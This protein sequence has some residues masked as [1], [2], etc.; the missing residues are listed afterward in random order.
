MIRTLI[1][2]VSVVCIHADSATRRG[3]I[4]DG[5][6][7]AR[8]EYPFTGL[9]G[10]YNPYTYQFFPVCGCTILGPRYVVTAAHCVD[11]EVSG[12]RL[13]VMT[14]VYSIDEFASD[15]YR[16]ANPAR[17]SLVKRADIHAEYDLSRRF[18]FTFEGTTRTL[19]EF[20]HDIALLELIDPTDWMPIQRFGNAWVVGGQNNV[21][22]MATAVGWGFVGNGISQMSDRPNHIE[23]PLVSQSRC[24]E[25]YWNVYANVYVGDDTHLCA[26]GLPN[27]GIC[28]GD[29]GSSLLK[30]AADGSWQLIGMPSFSLSPSP[31]CGAIYGEPT[32][33][34]RISSLSNWIC[35]RA[36]DVDACKHL[37]YNVEPAHNGSSF[38]VNLTGLNR[39]QTFLTAEHKYVLTALPSKHVVFHK[40]PLYYP[41]GDWKS[42]IGN[43]IVELVLEGDGS[44]FEIIYGPTATQID[45]RLDD[46]AIEINT[47]VYY[48]DPV[49]SSLKSILSCPQSTTPMSMAQIQSLM[50]DLKNSSRVPVPWLLDV[51]NNLVNLPSSL[52]F[53]L[54]AD[55]FGD[56]V[57]PGSLHQPIRRLSEEPP[58]IESINRSHP[59]F[60]NATQNTPTTTDP[61]QIPAQ[62]QQGNLRNESVLPISSIDRTMNV[63]GQQTAVGNSSNPSAQWLNGATPE[64]VQP[65]STTPSVPF[66]GSVNRNISQLPSFNGAPN[67]PTN[68]GPQVQ[69]R[70]TS[71]MTDWYNMIENS[72][73]NSIAQ[74]NLGTGPSRWATIQFKPSNEL[75]STVAIAIYVNDQRE[76]SAPIIMGGRL[77]VN[78]Y[79]VQQFC[80]IQSVT[81]D[82]IRDMMQ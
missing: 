52:K 37:S 47:D 24:T 34:T 55:E 56:G 66:I 32:V 51:Q 12:W 41:H 25:I 60:P 72:L 21:L 42:L 68:S 65:S 67:N 17:A 10:Y 48:M 38:T 81:P 58:R 63:P 39:P 2:A 75:M 79:D 7:T 44:V 36:P 29:S 69:W 50:Q 59:T 8:N 78:G 22:D 57:Q 28:N 40:L 70:S 76:L 46:T 74:L 19:N 73:T 27:R 53:A 4:V 5:E 13:I 16:S 3:L 45:I 64:P 23:I 9:S 80:A 20:A 77:V 30:K 33:F 15:M 18:E 61:D 14:G 49:S 54:N 43:D 6:E 11:N 71:S 35:S 62:W 31:N 26:G 1:C 82:D